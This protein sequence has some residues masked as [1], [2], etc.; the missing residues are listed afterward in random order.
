MNTFIQ[1]NYLILLEVRPCSMQASFSLRGN[2]LHV[3][4]SQLEVSNCS[5]T[6]VN[7][8]RTMRRYISED[9]HDFCVASDDDLSTGQLFVRHT[10]VII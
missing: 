2:L 7:F 1:I 5:D 3:L 9:F 10:V 4:Q 6:P 8:Y